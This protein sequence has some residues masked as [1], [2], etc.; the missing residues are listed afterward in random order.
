[1]KSTLDWKAT[2]FALGTSIVLAAVFTVCAVLKWPFKT[3]EYECY[4]EYLNEPN[5]FCERPRGSTPGET[6]IAQPLNTATNLAYLLVGLLIALYADYQH[7]EQER[8]RES[9]VEGKQ[10][11]APTPTEKQDANLMMQSRIL[12][13]L[14]S[15]LLC[16]V[17]FSSAAFHASMTDI[18][19]RFDE[20][21]ML[22]IGSFLMV[23]AC[24]RLCQQSAPVFLFAWS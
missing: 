18:G 5:C 10:E 23:Y 4:E 9:N 20:F 14:F 12:P 13:S 1:M 21:S 24:T 19:L 17:A 15:S 6:A 11:C 16:F 7:S 3:N 22:L 2:T 8:K